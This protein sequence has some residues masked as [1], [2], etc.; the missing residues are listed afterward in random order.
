MIVAHKLEKIVGRHRV[1]THEADKA[2]AALDQSNGL[3]KS[4]PLL[5]VKVSTQQELIDCVRCC[6]DFTTPIVIRACGTGKSGGAIAD[7]RSVVI[8]I[9]GLNRIITIDTKNLL[10]E[11]EPGVIL[12]DLKQAA[13][14]QGLYYPPDPASQDY[15]S[16]GGNVAENAAGPSTLK[17]GTTKDYVLGGQAII[18]TGELISFG[19]RCPKG[20]AGFDLASLLCGSEGTLAVFTNLI[21]RLIPHP[22]SQA[23]GMFYFNS[24][25]HALSAIYHLLHNGFLPKTLEY[26]DNTCLKALKKHTNLD[27]PPAQA[28]LMIECD[29][30][31]HDGAAQEIM[32]IKHALESLSLIHYELAT[33]QQEITTWWQLRSLLSEACT[34][35][36]GYKLSE[37]LAVPLGRLADLHQ[38]TLALAQPPHL[39][40]GLFGHAGDGNLHVQIM[41]DTPNLEAKAH[42]LCHQLLRVVVGLGGTIAA[43]HGI[44]LKKKS[45]LLFEQS[46]EL[47]EL[48][49]RIKRSFDPHNLLNPGKIF[50]V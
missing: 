39:Q 10:A 43:E 37:D 13:R 6:L 21:L 27:M 26:I 2:Y 11:V 12:A 22:T 35:Y 34:N 18:G 3:K 17:Y 8:D 23:L 29:A 38:A 28:A 5:V 25:E 33:T 1:L 36:L 42:E 47:I 46:D 31:G 20:V 19:K 14:E 44:G 7:A 15:C 49:K 48:Q 16:I 41:F 50:D 45:L 40:I 30:H 32:G 24:E 4:S 9:C